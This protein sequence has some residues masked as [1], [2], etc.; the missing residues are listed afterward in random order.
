[1]GLFMGI[2]GFSVCT[3]VHGFEA[4]Y[5]LT[6]MPCIVYSV[7]DGSPSLGGL[8]LTRSLLYG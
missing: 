6:E 2:V 8:C 4:G 7:V 5:F 3:Y 1:M